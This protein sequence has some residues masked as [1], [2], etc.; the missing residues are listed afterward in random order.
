MVTSE[1]EPFAKSGGLA[2]VVD[3]LARALGDLGHEVDVYLPRYRDLRPPAPAERSLLTVPL[4][5]P[6]DAP[7]ARS[8]AI[9][10]AVEVLTAGADGYRLRLVDHAPSFDRA[11]YYGEAGADYPDNG[12]RF[13]LLGRAALET[14]RAEGGG[15]AVLH[16]HDWQAG[17]AV[18]LRDFAWGSDP[19]LAGMATVVTCH[20]LA[21]HG[22]VPRERARALGLPAHVGK[23]DGVDLLREE[24]ARADMVNTVSPNYAVESRTPEYGGGLDDVLRARGDT[25]TG[26]LNG[27]D[28]RL[29][30]PET[31]GTL[32]ERFS[33]AD[34]AGK[35]ACKRDLASRLGLDDRGGQRG[36]WGGRGAPIFG[37]VGRL[38]PQKGFDLLAGAAQAMLDDGARIVVLGTGDERL[39][40]GL[41]QLAVR[42]PGRVAILDRF[43]RDE[44]R[45]IYAG[46]DLLLMPSRF[47]PCGQSQMIAM[48]Y[49]TVPVVRSTGGLADTVTDADARPDEGDG[50]A[51]VPAEPAALAAA[52]RRAIAAYRDEGRWAA[53]IS[54]AMRRDFSWA[55]SAPHYVDA[56]EQAIAIRRG[57][58][59]AAPRRPS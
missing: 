24:V 27:I 51:F 39:V 59:R 29:W 43:D 28:S 17:P 13:A 34:P 42:R 15:V 47:E 25:Y 8:G 37:M 26:I 9:M 5:A 36:G 19:V 12:A 41:R 21:Y 57:S 38:D 52:A 50:F 7:G 55:A 31:D 11:G 10:E 58:A 44:A 45:R 54:R 48:R 46:S 30:D 56:Y 1:C 4:P 14:I 35:L 18:L 40:R 32:A 23:A 20:N 22:W 16:G 49:G 53:L 3:A 6:P 33:S 2:D